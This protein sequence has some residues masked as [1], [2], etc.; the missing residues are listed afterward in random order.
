MDSLKKNK[1]QDRPLEER[2]LSQTEF[3]QW[4]IF[5]VVKAKFF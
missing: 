1:R 4:L 3:L 2:V 5:A